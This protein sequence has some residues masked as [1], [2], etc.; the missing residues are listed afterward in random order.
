MTNSTMLDQTGSNRAQYLHCSVRL[1]DVAIPLVNAMSQTSKYLRIATGS[2]EIKLINRVNES[3]K[4]EPKRQDEYVG[5]TAT[6]VIHTLLK[7][8]LRRYSFFSPK[9]FWNQKNCPKLS[10]FS[11]LLFRKGQCRM[12]Q[13][14]NN[15][16]QL[17]S[18]S[19]ISSSR[20]SV[21]ASTRGSVPSFKSCKGLL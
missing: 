20:W 5:N 7:C 2:A 6:L 14:S 21:C 19:C 4:L 11:D 13:R 3:S 9:H 1:W 16:M 10:F 8:V 18:V 15:S 17:G 12:P